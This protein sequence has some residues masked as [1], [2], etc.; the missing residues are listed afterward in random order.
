MLFIGLCLA[1]ALVIILFLACGKK[2]NPKKKEII[3]TVAIASS[4]YSAH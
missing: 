3:I 4:A 2:T 1:P